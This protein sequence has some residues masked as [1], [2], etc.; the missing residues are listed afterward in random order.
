MAMAAIVVCV[1][2]GAAAGLYFAV[3]EAARV[4]ENEPR[5]AGRRQ[6]RS[7]KLLL[8]GIPVL[9][10]T[11]IPVYHLFL[12][13][14]PSRDQAPNRAAVAGPADAAELRIVFQQNTL[15]STTSAADVEPAVIAI[16][17]RAH[18]V[19]ATCAAFSHQPA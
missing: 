16:A 11:P 6:H 9:L 5:S 4:V 14:S 8:V 10:W 3:D 12:F 1:A 7:G 15:T 18:A 2:A 17:G 19:R 13:R